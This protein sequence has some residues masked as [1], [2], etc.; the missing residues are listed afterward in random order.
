MV[1]YHFGSMDGLL[2]AVVEEMERRQRERRA[3]IG[4]DNADPASAARA[5]WAGLADPAIAAHERLFF[6]LYAQGLHGS[7]PMARL[8]KASIDEWLPQLTEMYAAATGDQEQAGVDARL[9]IAVL[10]GL[11][12]DLLA[13]GDLEAVTAAHERYLALYGV[14]MTQ[15]H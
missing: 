2:L 6:E 14:L 9:G 15:H 10:R 8:P 1:I 5:F 3:E 7:G 13:T 11:L 12:L 4:A